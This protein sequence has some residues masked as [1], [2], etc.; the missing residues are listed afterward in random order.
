MIHIIF[1]RKRD[2]LN[3]YKFFFSLQDFFFFVIVY[4]TLGCI[5]GAV[6]FITLLIPFPKRILLEWYHQVGDDDGNKYRVHNM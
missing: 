4:L 1:I 5:I 6:Q 3:S 2:S